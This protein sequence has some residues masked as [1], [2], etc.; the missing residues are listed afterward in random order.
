[1]MCR[2]LTT[3]L[4]TSKEPTTSTAVGA[5]NSLLQA[6]GTAADHVLLSQAIHEKRVK[7][8]TV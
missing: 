7:D 2:S 4:S 6:L 8:V 1:M 3:K 5:H